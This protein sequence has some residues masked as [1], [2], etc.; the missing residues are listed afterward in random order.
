VQQTSGTIEA[1]MIHSIL[2]GTV[3]TAMVLAPCVIALL[4][5]VDGTE[6]TR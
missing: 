2:V 5:G 4:T 1:T 6:K 3:Y